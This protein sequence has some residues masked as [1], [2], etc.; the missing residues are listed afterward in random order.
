MGAANSRFGNE[1]G[2]MFMGRVGGGEP[3]VP[4]K[5]AE[6]SGARACAAHWDPAHNA[7]R[8]TNG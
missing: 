4:K 2:P 1:M 3:G 7:A 8:W 5:E 6:Y